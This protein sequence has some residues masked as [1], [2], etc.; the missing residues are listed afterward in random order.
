MGADGTGYKRQRVTL[1]NDVERIGVVATFGSHKVARNILVDGA[2]VTARRNIAVEQRQL[3]L[4]VA[5]GRGFDGLAIE[6]VFQSVRHQR[7][8]LLCVDA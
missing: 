1:K 3:V 6:L 7:L 5:I 8:D 4:D 2:I